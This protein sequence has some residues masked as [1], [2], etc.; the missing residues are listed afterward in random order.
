[1]NHGSCYGGGHNERHQGP[2]YV[3]L[4]NILLGGPVLGTRSE[5]FVSR[6]AFEPF[7][8]LPF[9]LRL[10]PGNRARD[11]PKSGASA[12]RLKCCDGWELNAQGRLVRSL[13][14]PATI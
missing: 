12:N 4:H 8:Q 2:K 11:V 14:K 5:I 6:F 9:G 1:M 3:A 10:P 7:F 13:R